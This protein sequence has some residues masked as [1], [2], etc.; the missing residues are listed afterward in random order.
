M[1]HIRPERPVQQAARPVEPPKPQQPPKPAEPEFDVDKLTAMLDQPDPQPQ[2]VAEPQPAAQQQATLGTPTGAVGATLTM[3][4]IDALRSALSRCWSPP[5]G[6]TDPAQVRVVMLISLNPDGSVAGTEVVEAPPGQFARQAPESTIRAVRLC[7]PYNLPADK[8]D[9]W[10][11]LKIT[12]DPR[13]M[14]LL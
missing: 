13:D 11:Q 7:A 9:M 14:G 10:R 8:Y 4:E 2:P 5:I 12:F 3:S 6:Y 1:P